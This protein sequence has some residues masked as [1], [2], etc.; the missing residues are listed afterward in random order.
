MRRLINV[1][2]FKIPH[3]QNLF[4]NV[5]FRKPNKNL[6]EA[7]FN[8]IHRYLILP[9]VIPRYLLLSIVIHYYPTIYSSFFK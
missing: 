6:Y 8:L 5:D 7:L 2:N 4:L 9:I 3:S 1:E